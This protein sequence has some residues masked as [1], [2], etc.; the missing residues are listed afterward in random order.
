MK[1]TNQTRGG[2][3]DGRVYGVWYLIMDDDDEIPNKHPDAECCS[4]NDVSTCD[5]SQCMF[6]RN[7]QVLCL[8]R[9]VSRG[10]RFARFFPPNT[11][12]PHYPREQHDA[13]HRP[14]AFF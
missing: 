2:D 12:H 9:V 10:I 8:A 14:A 5:R 7:G 13:P 6:N 4:N 1:S 3:Y 11:S